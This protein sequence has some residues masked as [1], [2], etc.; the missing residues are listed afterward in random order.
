MAISP[1]EI[2]K[3]WKGTLNEIELE[4]S[5]ANFN[6]WFKS[7]FGLREKEKVFYVGVPSD[8]IKEWLST[9]FHKQI[10]NIIR[11][12]N[13]DIK[14]VKY[15]VSK[16]KTDAKEKKKE[17]D[18]EYSKTTLPFTANINSR[19][20]LNP[21][22]SFDKEFV[23]GPFNEL[24]YS[25]SQAILKKPGVYNPLFIY[26]PT[27]L[28]KT[29][30]IQ[31]VGNRIKENNPNI[32]IF[33]TTAETFAQE[34]INSI[35]NNKIAAYKE[36][37]RNYEVLIMDDIQ[38]LSGKEKTQEELFHLFN[39]LYN[40]GNQIIF[41]S[42]KH[43]NYINNLE[44]RLKSRFSAGMIVDITKPDFESRMAILKRKAQGIGIKI[45]EKLLGF[46][47]KH[48][49]GNIRE[50]EGIIN[51]LSCQI[52][53]RDKITLQEVK[54]TIKNSIKPKKQVSVKEIAK[55]ITDFYNLPASSVYEKTRKREVVHARQMTMYILREDF[56]ISFSVI[57][58]ELGGR[59]HTT[60]IHSYERI[61][62][63]LN[64]KPSITQELEQIR[65]ILAI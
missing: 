56:N 30:I 63:E 50:L 48:I 9:K 14:D 64:D 65:A 22:Y 34:Y 11:K 37:Y 21:R 18:K 28:G 1:K 23:I 47:A 42:D 26:G 36:K 46:I 6:T 8:F 43:P 38:F 4:V 20:K 24:A 62:K 12:Q 54:K 60:A 41:S 29:H 3:I 51:A 15:I 16:S 19:D 59:D 57:G 44:E 17:T 61:K 13:G 53:L 40:Q 58:K 25:A 10:L 32:K 33:Y 27:G 39:I 55:T 45:D 31:A 35:K 2:E 7:S 5:R 49:E 52:E